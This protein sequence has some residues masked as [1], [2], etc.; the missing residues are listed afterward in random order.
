MIM[1]KPKFTV[2][3]PKEN[4]EEQQLMEFESPSPIEKQNQ[5]ESFF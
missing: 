3:A 1:I 5:P 2:P 4:A